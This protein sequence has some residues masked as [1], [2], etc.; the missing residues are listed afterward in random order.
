MDRHHGF[1]PLAVSSDT[2]GQD[3]VTAGIAW[4]FTQA[5]LP[6]VVNAADYPALREFSARAEQLPEFAAAPHSEKV[7]QAP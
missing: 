3:G 7:Y 1:K 5:M 2:M 4:H 6:E